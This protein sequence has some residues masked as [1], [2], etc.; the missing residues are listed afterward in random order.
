MP[1]SGMEELA[2]A[3]AL[4]P[5][6]RGATIVFTL[7]AGLLAVRDLLAGAHVAGIVSLASIAALGGLTALL[8]ARRMLSLRQLRTLELIAF[9][10]MAVSLTVSH[11]TRI[12]AATMAGNA[13]AATSHWHE[14]A[15][16]CVVLLVAYGILVPNTWQRAARIIIPTAAIPFVLGLLVRAQS[17]KSAT[18]LPGLTAATTT[19]VL[20]AMATGAVVAILG[21][22]LT[23]KYRAGFVHA[24]LAGMYDLVEKIGSGGM[25]E[26]WLAR[27]HVLSR[28]AA[29]KLI[30]PELLGE[31]G[32]SGARA[33]R[34]FEREAQVTAKLRSPHTV[35]LYDFGRSQTGV[36]YYVMEYLDGLD[37][38]LLVERFGPVP[39]ERAVHFLLQACDALGDAHDHNLIHRDIKPANI[40]ACRMG[41]T[42]DY[43]KVL[44]FG[45]V[46]P[47]K[48]QPAD[49]TITADG[50]ATGTPAYMPPEMITGAHTVDARSDLY[51][52]GCVGYWLLSGRP[53]FESGT[54]LGVLVD[55]VKTEPS[56]V[57]Q[58]AE[59]PIPQELD[60]ILLQCVAKN[61][62]DRFQSARQLADAL[63][64]CPVPE[65]W[66]SARAEQWWKLHQPQS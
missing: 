2:T 38:A 34:R 14:A 65:T 45:L 21:T 5:L 43:I 42:Y 1:G 55:H 4:Q 41:I 60:R 26:V 48:E 27:H 15:L 8:F 30:R 13:A 66:T 47:G 12:L 25:G 22:L 11:Y 61:P 10:A 16:H 57:S 37:L 49:P 6:L 64:A 36:F 24:S 19:P 56:P 52:L 62:A 50:T 39:V 32:E 58:R 23:S 17:P 29:I 3:M 40:H 35:E 31:G 53:L 7:F 20:L 9:G 44:D 63:A 54:P 46:K 33:V 51:S 18:L 59:I 28:P